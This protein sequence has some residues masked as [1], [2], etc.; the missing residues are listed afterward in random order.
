MLTGSLSER[1]IADFLFEFFHPL[2]DKGSSMKCWHHHC[3]CCC[4]HCD[5]LYPYHRHCCSSSMTVNATVT[6][7]SASTNPDIITTITTT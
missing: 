2:H 6:A 7:T 1:S 3:C 4:H 5:H